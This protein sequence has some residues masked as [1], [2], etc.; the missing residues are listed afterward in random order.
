M[1]LHDILWCPVIHHQKCVTFFFFVFLFNKNEKRK[2]KQQVM[3]DV[4]VHLMRSYQFLNKS[5]NQSNE[6]ASL[7]LSYFVLMLI[8]QD[9]QIE[10]DINDLHS[11]QMNILSVVL[12][13]NQV[14]HAI[15]FL[16]FEHLLYSLILLFQYLYNLFKFLVNEDTQFNL[17][18]YYHLIQY[19]I[20]LLLYDTNCFH[21][22][23]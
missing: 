3:I 13:I 6:I 8:D 21:L 10:V 9:H 12:I 18:V 23:L 5:I 4:S 19:L 16:F 1:Q 17:T 2:T 20:L 15:A 7:F 22:R 11:M 14:H